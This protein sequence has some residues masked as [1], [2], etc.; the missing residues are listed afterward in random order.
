MTLSCCLHSVRI[1]VLIYLRLRVRQL[2]AELVDIIWKHVGDQVCPPHQG[3]TPLVST[4][5]TL[6]TWAWGS[7]TALGP[8]ACQ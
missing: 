3:L 8:I 1:R 2:N 7:C 4:A 6:H 5:C